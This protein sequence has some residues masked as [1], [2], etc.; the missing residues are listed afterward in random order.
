MIIITHMMIESDTLCNRIAIVSEGK[1]K[2]IGSQQYLKNKFGPG[3]I[4][5][6]NLVHNG[7][8][9][10]ERA[11]AFVRRQLHPDARLGIRQVKTLHVSTSLPRVLKLERSMRSHA[12]TRF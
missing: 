2:V 7:H 9:Y 4:L 1:L 12:C 11:M 6:L 3:Y 10:Q 5:H 8:D